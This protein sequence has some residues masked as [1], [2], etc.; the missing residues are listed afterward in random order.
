MALGSTQPLVKMSTRN[1]P[2]GKGGRCVRLKTS[3]PS[4]AECHEIWEPKTPGTLWATPGLWR[5]FL[6]IT[7][8]IPPHRKHAE[9]PLKIQPN[10]QVFCDVTLCRC[11]FS[12]FS[13]DSSAFIHRVKRSKTSSCMWRWRVL[14]G[15]GSW[16]WWMAKQP[17]LAYQLLCPF[18]ILVT[19]N[20]TK[21]AIL[22]RSYSCGN[23][24]TY[25][26]KHGYPSKGVKHPVTQLYILEDLIL[27]FVFNAA[28]FCEVG[29]EFVNI[30]YLY[31]WG[32]EV[33]NSVSLIDTN[34]SQLSALL[35]WLKC[36]LH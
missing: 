24:W 4:R 11:V 22:L 7:I 17:L 33:L 16:G 35:T 8:H 36:T 9:Y 30:T 13:K 14:C 3:P 18:F 21:H 1:I 12:D 10:Y 25:R 32:C 34:V 27:S 28:N 29:A 31:I 15:R 5:D 6:P 2:G 20:H 26:R 23:A 19:H